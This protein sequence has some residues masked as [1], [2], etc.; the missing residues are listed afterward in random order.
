VRGI[1]KAW[2]HGRIQGVSE[3]INPAILLFCFIPTSVAMR[4]PA[5]NPK[6]ITRL[7]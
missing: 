3:H 7:D 6:T 5:Q 4:P 2:F 1:S